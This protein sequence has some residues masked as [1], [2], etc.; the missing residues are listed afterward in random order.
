M[1]NLKLHV[2]QGA[3]EVRISE[4]GGHNKKVYQ[5]SENSKNLDIVYATSYSGKGEKSESYHN[6]YIYVMAK[7]DN[8]V[9]NIQGTNS[10]DYKQ[11]DFGVPYPLTLA[12]S[13]NETLYL[14]V[15]GGNFHR[16]YINFL[17]IFNNPEFYHDGKDFLLTNS[18]IKPEIVYE[19]KDAHSN[20][21]E[22]IKC[23]NT[24][25][26]SSTYQCVLKSKDNWEGK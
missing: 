18:G 13:R 26:T 23:Y 1:V 17:I 14:E 19:R 15:G 8:A 12:P 3:V 9:Y 20:D 25:I 21:F 6:V 10:N 16:K 7:T 11:I 24:H 4:T 5:I 22:H 2:F